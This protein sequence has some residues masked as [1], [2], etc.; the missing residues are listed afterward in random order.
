MSNKIK[1]F[2][3]EE[4][5]LEMHKVKIV[6]KLELKPIERRLAA[7]QEA[8]NNSF[9]LRNRDVFLDMLTDSGVNAMSN[10]QQSAMLMADDCYAGG[11][12]FFRLEAVLQKV[13][14]KKYYIP[15]HQGRA[16]EHL[17][18]RVLVKQGDIVPMNYHFTTTKAHIRLQGGEI[19]EIPVDEAF[20]VKSTCQFKG[21]IDIAKLEK[22]FAEHKENIPFVMLQAGTNLIGGQPISLQNVKDVQTVCKKNG[23]P[24]VFDASLLQDNLYFMKIR[25]EQ[26]KDMSILEICNEVADNTDIIYFSARKFGCAKGGGICLNNEETFGE[27]RQF[28]TLFEGFLTYGGM[29]D[30]EIEAV[31]IG[32]SE[33]M[34][35]DVISQGPQ[36][37]KFMTDELLKAGVPVMMPAGGLGCHLDARAFL[38]HLKPEEFQAASLTSALY[39]ISGIRG[40]E[41]GTMAEERNADGS[42]HIAAIELVRLAL[43][44]RV[45]TMSQ[46]KFAV[47]RISWLY[48]NREIIGGLKWKYEPK[49]LRFFLGQFDQISN[50]QEKL[51]EKFK[52]DFGESL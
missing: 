14:N 12:S 37:I 26:C 50:W 30:K 45:F 39:I 22:A 49:I 21:N 2:C 42:E 51:V 10:K 46:I 6:Q 4:L 17:L 48:Q 52:A 15:A 3:G 5:P 27:L 35:F 13:F 47:D 11:E 33:S 24:L 28:V 16:C 1:L 19:L 40:M 18:S 7:V 44:R 31:A 36:F 32:I 38:S 23:V 41:R 8:G 34:D 25:E 20:N 43:P 9:L 29:S